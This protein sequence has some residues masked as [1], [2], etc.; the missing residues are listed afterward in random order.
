MRWPA[1]GPPA[2]GDGLRHRVREWRGG[3]TVGGGNEGKEQGEGKAG[4]GHGARA[5]SQLQV[6]RG[7]EH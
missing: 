6:G 2:T 3:V 4:G 7:A 1:Q 5:K